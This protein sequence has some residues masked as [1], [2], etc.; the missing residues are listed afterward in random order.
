MH[1]MKNLILYP[2]PCPL[3]QI[4]LLH[5]YNRTSE[6]IYT[7]NSGGKKWKYIF[8]HPGWVQT[9]TKT[10]GN[11]LTWKT[12]QQL[13]LETVGNW[14]WCKLDSKSDSSTICVQYVHW[15][16]PIT[17]SQYGGH[18]SWYGKIFVI[19]ANFKHTFQDSGVAYC[20]SI[21]MLQLLQ[22]DRGEETSGLMVI[23][24]W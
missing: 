19:H 23:Y 22:L 20:H 13:Y 15:R 21:H 10:K 3:P 18:P 11:R 8:K 2:F 6:Y 14:I 9:L 5:N 17:N 7:S 12:T 16:Q 1:Y 24:N 4:A